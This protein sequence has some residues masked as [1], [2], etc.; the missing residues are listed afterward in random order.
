MPKHPHLTHLDEDIYELVNTKK[1]STERHSSSSGCMYG[2]QIHL[3]DT[4]NSMSALSGGT[5][6]KR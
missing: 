6:V 2:A 1:N 3:P 4:H 5:L